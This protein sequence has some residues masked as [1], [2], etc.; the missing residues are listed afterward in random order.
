MADKIL[1]INDYRKKTD[2]TEM[3]IQIED[4]FNF[5]SPE[6][7]DEYLRVQNKAKE[8]ALKESE[9]SETKEPIQ[10]Q[11]E[12]ALK[13]IEKSEG[14]EVSRSTDNNN[15]SKRKNIDSKSSDEYDEEEDEDYEDDDEYEDDYEEE[16][17]KRKHHKRINP[18]KIV[19]IASIVTGI[20]IL[21]LIAAILKANVFDKIFG[22][23]DAETETVTISL[24]GGYVETDDVVVAT[25]DVNLRSVPSTES[26]DYIV[27]AI[28]KGTEVKRLGV[29]EDGSWAY[30][31]YNGQQ[32]YCYMGY[33]EV[34][35]K[36]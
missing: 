17:E 10:N 31:E 28:V 30:V 11:D 2:D 3:D 27:T 1:N 34:K 14:K 25:S 13:D 20:L 35:Q 23:K 26:K 5:L 36:Q 4:P 24:P 19:R 29:S 6:E 22:T 12:E 8:D 21:V 7:R 32:L 9:N 18:E 15:S 33:L 16:Y